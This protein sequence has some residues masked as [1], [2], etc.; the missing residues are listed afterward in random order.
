MDF[1]ISVEKKK[2]ESLFD[3]QAFIKDN[4]DKTLV[5]EIYNVYK[6]SRRF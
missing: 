2:L 5:F 6:Q 4:E 3:F 1:I